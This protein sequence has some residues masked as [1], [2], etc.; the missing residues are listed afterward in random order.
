MAD[1]ISKVTFPLGSCR[2]QSVVAAVAAHGD[3]F[4]V[5][6]ETTPFH[7][8]DFMWPDQPEDLGFIE[9]KDGRRYPLSDTVV[10]GIS[11]E[12]AFFFD[13]EIPVKKSDPDW[14][15]C[16]GHVISGERPAL[17][18]G[19]AVTLQVDETRRA[20]LSRAHSA[21]HLMSLALN[22]AFTPL[23]RKDAPNTDAL[24]NPH[25]DRIAME[26]SE[27]GLLASEDQYRL[28]KS[29]RKKG[30]QTEELRAAL[31]RLVDEIN[32][33]V[34]AWLAADSDIQ[35][36]TEGDALTSHRYWTASVGGVHAEIPC[37]GT[38][39]SSFKE[40]GAFT[41]AAEM[42]NDEA[43]IVKITVR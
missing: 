27:L 4:I 15:F 32:E 14:T 29:L 42:P 9:D 11:P 18:K 38:H 39:V 30:F 24:G 2:E 1:F 41:V 20:E 5:M 43:L 13:K 35:I 28:G 17:S 10:A 19:D 34:A 8:R 33:T 23:W 22:K 3:D 36:R 31:P 25:F 12:G 6:T 16:V 26:Q 40:I 37:G 7:P 21:S